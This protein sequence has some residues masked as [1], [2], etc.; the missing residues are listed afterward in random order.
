MSAAPYLPTHASEADTASCVAESYSRFAAWQSVSEADDPPAA[1]V[2]AGVKW[3][4]GGGRGGQWLN[5]AT[6]PDTE[7]TPAG[8]AASG[9]RAGSW[10]RASGGGGGGRKSATPAPVPRSM[11]ASA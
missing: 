1:G 7:Q 11:R 9:W 10:V 8:R 5:V 6:V 3:T 2:G 4:A